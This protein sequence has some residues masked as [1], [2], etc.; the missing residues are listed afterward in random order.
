[1]PLAS[2]AGRTA[3]SAPVHHAAH[4]DRLRL[5]SHLAARDPREIEQVVDELHLHI[6]VADDRVLRAVGQLVRHGRPLWSIRAQ[7]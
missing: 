2:A 1:M 4:V 5:E 3:S 6:G 7:P